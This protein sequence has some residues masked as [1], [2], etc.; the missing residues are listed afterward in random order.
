[1]LSWEQSPGIALMRRERAW[2]EV[3]LSAI[4]HNVQQIRR[5]LSYQTE[6]MAVVKADA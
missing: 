3:N 2:V 4:A 5:L 1:M 6:L